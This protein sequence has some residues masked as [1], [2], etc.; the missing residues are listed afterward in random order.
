[1]QQEMLPEL[2]ENMKEKKYE[3]CPYVNTMAETP[4]EGIVGFMETPR[5][6]TGYAALFNTIGFVTEAHMFK[7]YKDRVLATYEFLLSITI[8][9][10]REHKKIGEIRAQAKQEV[11]FQNNFHL[12]WKLDT[13][14]F[15][16]F[17]FKG[18]EVKYETSNISGMQ[19]LYYDRKS[20]FEKP[21]RFYNEYIPEVTIQK[22]KMYIIPQ[23]WKEVIERLKWNDVVLKRLSRD[24]TL[25]VEVYYIANHKTSER[26]YEGHYLHNK[27]QVKK[28]TQNIN[29]FKGDYVVEVNQAANRYIVET[30]EPQATDSYFAWNFFDEILQQKEW[31][32]SYIFEEMAEEILINNPSLKTNLDQK[33]KQDSTFANNHWAQLYFVYQHST[34][35]ENTHQRYP[36]ARLNDQV[37]LAVE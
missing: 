24:T 4:D 37:R 1:M 32:S 22:P 33:K 28:E 19:R 36:I 34:Y 12:S 17:P 20:P 16:Y 25:S 5:Y 29:Y 15:E 6:S 2:Y 30:I 35:F 27:V 26:P 31:F 7:P 9:T 18:F 14:K 10:N 23:A 11:A 13:T 3:M 21:V 8:L